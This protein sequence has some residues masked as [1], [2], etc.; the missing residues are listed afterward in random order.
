MDSSVVME[1]VEGGITVT[2]IW[3]ALKRQGI[4]SPIA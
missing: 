1:E 3:A 2:H 4:K